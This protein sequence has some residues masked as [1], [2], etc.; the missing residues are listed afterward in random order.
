M[1]IIVFSLILKHIMKWQKIK[2]AKYLKVLKN[3]FFSPVEKTQVAMFQYV[4]YLKRCA[5]T[6]TFCGKFSLKYVTAEDRRTV[7]AI[8]LYR[9]GKSTSRQM[10]LKYDRTNTES[11]G[12]FSPRALPQQA[13]IKQRGIRGNN[14]RLTTSIRVV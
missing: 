14:L 11:I 1:Q 6:E 9:L 8:C 13:Q 2:V 3:M 7:P 4:F 10:W 12:R 5:G